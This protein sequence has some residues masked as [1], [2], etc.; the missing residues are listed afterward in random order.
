MAMQTFSV[1][2]FVGPIWSLLHILYF[3]ICFVLF[4]FV[5]FC[6]HSPL[7]MLN[8]LS[9]RIAQKQATGQIGVVGHFVP[10]PDLISQLF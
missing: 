3:S 4:S 10:T 2:D 1:K 7:K 5:L 8:S 6:F 9:G